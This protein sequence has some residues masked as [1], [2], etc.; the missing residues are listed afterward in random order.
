MMTTYE[1]AK[2]H[3]ILLLYIT[4]VSGHRAATVAIEKAIKIFD[5]MTEVMSLNGFGYTYPLLEKVVNRAYM[6]I[7]KR[8]PKV[9]DYLYDNPNVFKRSEGI[10]KYLHKTS[11]QKLGDL[12]SEFNPDTVICTQAFPCGMVAD[13]KTEHRL[14]VKLIGVLTDYAPHSYWLN[15]GVDYY[16]V[17]SEDAKWRFLTKGVPEE[18]I[19]LFGIPIHANFELQKDRRKIADRLGIDLNVPTILIM[20]GGQG[21]GPIKQVVQ[22]LLKVGRP[23][24]ML[25]I[26]GVNQ[27]LIRWLKRVRRKENKKLFVFEYVDYVDELMEVATLIITKPGG[28]TTSECLAKGLPMVIVDPLPGQEMRNT[29]FLLQNGI[30]IRIDKT[31]DLGEEVD[32]LLQNPLR[33]KEMREAA[34]AY[35][36]PHAA[37]DI[38]RLILGRD[39]SLPQPAPI[40]KSVEQSMSDV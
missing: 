33:L 35:G 31:N 12:F 20:G 11:H 13:Y 7:I 17:P 30:A 29:D 15:E 9:W 3:R 27:K 39:A 38:A 19:K 2:A 36:R 37:M 21:L 10:K 24:Q 23:L 34:F 4:K 5:P 28:M 8:T 18:R 22:S 40:R 6:G 16:V 32:L 26:A 14:P 25:V 1:L